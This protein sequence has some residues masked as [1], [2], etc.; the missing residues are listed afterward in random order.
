MKRSELFDR[1]CDEVPEDILKRVK[2]NID[3]DLERI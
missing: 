1:L 2:R 3:K